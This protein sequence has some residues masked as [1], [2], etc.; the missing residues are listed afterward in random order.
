LRQIKLRESNDAFS[1]AVA[2]DTEFALAY[3]KLGLGTQL[4]KPLTAEEALERAVRYKDRLRPSEQLLAQGALALQRGLFSE[5]DA[6]FREATDKF[7]GEGETWRALGEY[8][9]HHGPARVHGDALVLRGLQRDLAQ[10]RAEQQVTP[11]D[12]GGRG[13]FVSELA[14]SPM[15]TA[16]AG[17]RTPSASEG[18]E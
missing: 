17:T 14:S 9:F 15:D 13:G 5:A 10:H 8:Y 3:Y 11:A 16:T 7:P 4:L 1:R 18:C 12:A 2:A 6:K